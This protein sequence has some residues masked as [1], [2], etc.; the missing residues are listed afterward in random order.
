[1]AST[2]Y[3]MTQHVTGVQHDEKKIYSSGKLL[4][5]FMGDDSNLKSDG[6]KYIYFEVAR[7]NQEAAWK[8]AQENNLPWPP[9]PP[10]TVGEK[11]ADIG[12]VL[13]AMAFGIPAMVASPS[14][15][16][17]SSGASSSGESRGKS[18]GKSRGRR[19]GRKTVRGG[20]RG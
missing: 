16:K 19:G 6:D 7:K 20:M 18:R 15:E 1:M 11:V 10:K 17:D 4:V 5:Q 3:P 13:Y 8:Y 12:K 2:R 14:Q 9:P